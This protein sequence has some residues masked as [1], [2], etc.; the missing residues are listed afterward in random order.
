LD[1]P[2]GDEEDSSVEIVESEN[3][4]PNITGTTL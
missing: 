4:S 2:D 3:K 1:F